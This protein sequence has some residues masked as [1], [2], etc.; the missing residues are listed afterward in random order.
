MGAN[1]CGCRSEKTPE[2]IDNSSI[3]DTSAKMVVYLNSATLGRG[4]DDLGA[5]LMGAY[6][7]TLANFAAEISHI[8][9]VNSGVKLACRDSNVTDQL[10]N[11]ANTGIK[12]LSCGTCINFF[13]L[14]DKLVVGDISNMFEI[15]ETIKNGGRT[16]SP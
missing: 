13:D 12:V 11:L 9:L 1:N 6:L 15:I 16:I 4:D 10:G 7:D 3:A 5:T 2:N 8:I 14:K